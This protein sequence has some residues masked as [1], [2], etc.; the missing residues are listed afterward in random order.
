MQDREDVGRRENV[1]SSAFGVAPGTTH[2][3]SDPAWMV[4]SSVGFRLAREAGEVVTWGTMFGYENA[5]WAYRV[6]TEKDD[7]DHFVGFRLACN[8]EGK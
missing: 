6:K 4:H 3:D 2:T 7:Y 5:A 1:G 8:W